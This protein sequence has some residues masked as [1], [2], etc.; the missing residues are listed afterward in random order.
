MTCLRSSDKGSQTDRKLG[1]YRYCPLDY[2]DNSTPEHR[3][4]FDIWSLGYIIVELLVLAIYG[5]ESKKL[6]AFKAEIVKNQEIST[7]FRKDVISCY[8]NIPVVRRWIN[9]MAREDRSQNFLYLVDIATS[10]LST[11]SNAR[12]YS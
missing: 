6:R 3:R 5:W 4:S 1:T 7:V 11:N 10:M 2:E 8:N 9:T 12:P